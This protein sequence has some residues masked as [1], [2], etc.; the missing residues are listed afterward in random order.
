MFG[1]GLALPIP[2]PGSLSRGFA[3][4]IAEAEALANQASAERD[5]AERELRLAIAS[6]VASFASHQR[7]VDALTPA[8][9]QRAEAVL[10]ELASQIDA[11]R[12]SAREALVFQQ[13]LIELLQGNI[14]E[15]K[16]LC[17]ASLELAR[18]L[19]VPIEGG[20]R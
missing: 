3:G 15:R 18:A 10:G 1:V 4:E 11:G 16:A 19:G 8:A 6:A 13:P 5:A 7:A 20:A 14:E 17:L 9:L 2:L 12:I